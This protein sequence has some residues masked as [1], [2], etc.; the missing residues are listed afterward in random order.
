MNNSSCP[1]CG[2]SFI[3]SEGDIYVCETHGRFR[4]GVLK[5]T[6]FKWLETEGSKTHVTDKHRLLEASPSERN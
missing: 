3:L 1:F 2:R 6:G 5:I 4:R